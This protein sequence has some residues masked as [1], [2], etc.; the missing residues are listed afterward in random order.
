MFFSGLSDTGGVGLGLSIA[1]EIIN[2]HGGEIIAASSK[3][4]GL[5]QSAGQRGYRNKIFI[6]TSRKNHCN[7][8][9]NAVKS[10]DKNISVQENW[11]GG[12]ISD[13]EKV[14]IKI[15]TIIIVRYAIGS[16]DIPD[17]YMRRTTYC[18]NKRKSTS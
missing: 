15:G 4:R 3:V 1:R 17:Y 14:P 11:M 5:S 6:G 10:S 2:L 8:K 16:R 9:D 12:K 7:H 18:D 13:L